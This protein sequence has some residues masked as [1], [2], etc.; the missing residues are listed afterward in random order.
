MLADLSLVHCYNTAAMSRNER[1]RIMLNSAKINLRSMAFFGEFV[2]GW[3]GNCE[4]QLH[5]LLL[6]NQF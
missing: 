3:S 1:D 2:A 4:K 6:T 5:K